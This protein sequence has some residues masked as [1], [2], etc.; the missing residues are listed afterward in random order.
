MR[1]AWEPQ[2]VEYISI[3][4]SGRREGQGR[5]YARIQRRGQRAGDTRR[6]RGLERAG[7][8]SGAGSQVDPKGESLGLL[9]W[10]SQVPYTSSSFSPSVLI[11]AALGRWSSIESLG[12]SEAEE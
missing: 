11:G 2:S 5:W 4:G 12:E 9:S 10:C 1:E 3:L 7:R 6:A 8:L